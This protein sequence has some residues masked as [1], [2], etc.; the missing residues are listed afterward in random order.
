MTVLHSRACVR[1]RECAC[2][3]VSAF[4][5]VCV[6]VCC[7]HA[8]L[9]A[10]EQVWHGGSV[11]LQLGDPLLPDVLEAGGVDDWE[12]DEEDVGH[13]VG[14]RSQPVVVLLHTGSTAGG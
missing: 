7:W 4:V 13:W 1:V 12:T 8:D 6:C 14:Q 5:C 2:V 11:L 9:C 3:C 10:N